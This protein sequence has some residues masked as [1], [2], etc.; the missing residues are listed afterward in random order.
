VGGGAKIF[1]LLAS[2]DVEGD[3]VDLGVTVLA[4]LR[5]RHVDNLAGT[6]LDADKTVLP[7]SRTLHG[8]GGRGAGISRLEG[9]VMLKKTMMLA[10]WFCRRSIKRRIKY[11]LTMAQ[12]GGKSSA[13]TTSIRRWYV[14]GGLVVCGR[15]LVLRVSNCIA[16]FAGDFVDVG[17][18]GWFSVPLEQCEKEKNRDS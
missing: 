2:E 1:K 10:V 5:G 3:Q 11:G 15:A 14:L 7:Q 17:D 9:V 16:G 8:V 6:V 18:A 12:A 13:T 4:S